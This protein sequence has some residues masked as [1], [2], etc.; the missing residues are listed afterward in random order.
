MAKRNSK[1]DDM[2]LASIKDHLERQ[3]ETLK[4]ILIVLRGSISMGVSGIIK[5]H[6]TLRQQLGKLTSDV[7]HYERWRQKQIADKGKITI[8]LGQMFTRVMALIGGVGTLVGI[9][10]ALKQLFDNAK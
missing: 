1:D 8:S 9:M 7:A 5:D 4:E 6:D 2:E 3:D 10:L